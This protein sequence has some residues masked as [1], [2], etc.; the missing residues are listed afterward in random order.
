M[1][2]LEFYLPYF[3]KVRQQGNF[4]RL[5][6]VGVMIYQHLVNIKRCMIDIL[7]YILLS[8]F[9]YMRLGLSATKALIE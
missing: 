5:L 4:T 1:S 8:E 6:P 2:R 3:Y 9:R 7:N